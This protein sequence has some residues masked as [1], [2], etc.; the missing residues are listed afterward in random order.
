M[1][2]IFLL[3]IISLSFAG[4]SIENTNYIAPIVVTFQPENVLTTSA[5]LGGAVLAEGGKNISEY[6][7]VYGTSDNP[8]T[9]DNKIIKGE[10]MGEFFDNYTFF[11]PGVTYYYRT[12]A[13]SEIA[14]GYG[15]TFSF[16][17]QDEAPCN[18]LQ[19]NTL[20]TGD[21]FNT[22]TF[23]TVWMEQFSGLDGNVTF[24]AVP[25]T[26]AI[27]I[28]LNFNEIDG[29]LP[30]T[31]TYTTVSEFD[32]LDAQ[33]IGNVKFVLYNYGSQIGGGTPPEGSKVYVENNNGD[34]TFTFC[35]FY[36][37]Q[38]YN[39]NGKFTYTETE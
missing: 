33:S 23:Y 26:T 21:Y 10:R 15:E 8:T 9:S 24:E 39:L 18:P 17:T 29:R 12:Y 1:K 3:F 31:G 34:V 4:C 7:I 19:D 14:T 35:D 13:I 37:N 20:N 6:G 11:E 28:I 16:T 25:N 27:Q 5:S 2:R 36:I 32:S 38:Y 30:L 22:I